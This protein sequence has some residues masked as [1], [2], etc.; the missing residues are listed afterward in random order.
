VDM[1][2]AFRITFTCESLNEAFEK[3]CAVFFCEIEIV[4]QV[5]DAR[6][7]QTKWIWNQAMN[8]RQWMY[9][10]W[11]NCQVYETKFPLL[12][13]SS[14]DSDWYGVLIQAIPQI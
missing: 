5:K 12:S 8:R 7:H 10:S 11:I 3:W 4:A 6:P 2:C 14:R 1:R 9:G 13:S